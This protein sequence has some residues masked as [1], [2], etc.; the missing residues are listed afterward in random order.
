[1]NQKKKIYIVLAKWIVFLCLLF[2]ALKLVNIDKLENGLR[3]ISISTLAF[4]L[5]FSTIS[6]IIYSIRWYYICTKGFNFSNVSI[7]FLFR[8]NLLAEFF[9]IATPSSLGGEALRILKLSSSGFNNFDSAKT[10]I[11]DRI[12][13]FGSMLL[14]AAILLPI[15]GIPLIGNINLN[16]NRI[17]FVITGVIILCIS[18]V[19]ALR[20]K[21]ISDFANKTLSQIWHNFSLLRYTIALSIAGHFIFASTFYLIFREIH[22]I[23]FLT[24][25]TLVFTSQ[26]TRFVPISVLGIGLGEGTLI[27]LA[28]LLEIKTESILIVVLIALGSRYLFA[29]CGLFVEFWYDGR[30]LLKLIFSQGKVDL[31]WP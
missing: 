4:Y 26:I 23:P 3:S 12:I 17:Y 20:N 18:F 28:G 29:I 27:G 25:I 5:L 6:R 9:G 7:F 24:A 1:V 13:G 19:L 31:S 14:L 11:F 10:V 22:P 15:Y 2:V 21:P 30:T 16:A 8:L